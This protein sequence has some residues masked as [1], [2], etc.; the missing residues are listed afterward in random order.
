MGQILE[1][2]LHGVGESRLIKKLLGNIITVGYD[3]TTN[4][5][6]IVIPNEKLFSPEQY[7]VLK[8]LIKGHP[9]IVSELAKYG[10]TGYNV[11]FAVESYDDS[12]IM[13]SNRDISRLSKLSNEI[14]ELSN[15]IMKYNEDVLERAR[16]VE[17]MASTFRSVKKDITISY[18]IELMKDS[19]PSD[20]MSKVI[21]ETLRTAG[22]DAVVSYS[23]RP[24]ADYISE[25]DAVK[26]ADL[27]R[28]STTLRIETLPGN[29]LR[30]KV[31]SALFSMNLD[32]LVKA[33]RILRGDAE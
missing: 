3:K 12:D 11:E 30:E 29:N 16:D 19:T 13:V 23:P 24:L 6:Y 31:A 22:S 20:P 28:R 33:M 2:A 32:D 21:L 7:T 14:A 8:K 18:I 17:K 10:V 15:A 1:Q 27:I 25:E 4:T 5:F 9:K 26:L